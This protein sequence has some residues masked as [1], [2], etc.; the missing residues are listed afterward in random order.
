MKKFFLISFML[1]CGIALQSSAYAPQS[2][3]AGYGCTNVNIVTTYDKHYPQ[4]N[5]I[6]KIIIS[7]G[8]PNA[9][10]TPAPPPPP[11]HTYKYKDFAGHKR[12]PNRSYYIPS[13][14]MPEEGF[15]TGIYNPFCNHYRPYGSNLYLRF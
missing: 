11:R 12:Y 8:T 3:H 1:L 15:N 6:N 13:Y 2:T 9:I 4:A 14:C 7:S 10:I 5:P